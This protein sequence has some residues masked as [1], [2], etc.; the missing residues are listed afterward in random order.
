MKKMCSRLSLVVCCIA[1]AAYGSSA[2][3]S[4]LTISREAV[5]ALVMATVFN[6]QGKWYLTKGA[7]FAYLERPRV[8][9]AGGRLIIDGHLSSRVGLDVGSS[10]V[11]TDFASDVRISG[12][13][14]DAGSQITLNDIRIDNV[15]DDS[16][17]QALDLIQSAAGAAM[18]KAVNIDLLQLIK[19]TVVTGMPVRVVVTGLQIEAVTTQ[20][21]KVTVDFE[22]KITA[23]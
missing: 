12:R 22:M 15:K 20:P 8:S 7:C 17:R 11:G 6:D 16:T 3:A 10:C 23:R 5:Q 1:S 18:P 4:E 2:A 21:D 14:V 19:P 13:L 9:L